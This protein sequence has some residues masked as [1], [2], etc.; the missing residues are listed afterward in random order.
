[1]SRQISTA[2]IDIS[3]YF[4]RVDGRPT[5]DVFGDF[6]LFYEHPEGGRPVLVF[7]HVTE[8]FIRMYCRDRKWVQEAGQKGWK[9]FLVPVRDSGVLQ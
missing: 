4:P 5:P 9:F 3:R 7:S 1:M 6:A 8:S 2:A